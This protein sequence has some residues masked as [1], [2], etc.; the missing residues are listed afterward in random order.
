MSKNVSQGGPPNVAATARAEKPLTAIA[1]EFTRGSGTNITLTFLP[2]TEISEQVEKK[3]TKAD[4][5]VSL[6]RGT[7][8]EW[9]MGDC[10]P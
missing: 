1:E 10:L 9:F 4:V 5:V 2:Q 8:P 6:H 7:V 3:Q